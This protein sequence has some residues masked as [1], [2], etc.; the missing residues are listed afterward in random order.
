M[1]M[2]LLVWNGALVL[3]GILVIQSTHF[4]LQMRKWKLGGFKPHKLLL[5]ERTRAQVCCSLAQRLSCPGH[6]SSNILPCVPC[7]WNRGPEEGSCVN[8]KGLWMEE[9]ELEWPPPLFASQCFYFP[10]GGLGLR[11]SLLRRWVYRW[12]SMACEGWPQPWRWW[13]AG[14]TLSVEK[15]R[16]R[17][18]GPWVGLEFTLNMKLLEG[19]K[20][21]QV[22]LWC[23]FLNTH[24]QL[25][26]TGLWVLLLGLWLGMIMGGVLLCI[27]FTTLCYCW[28][29]FDYVLLL[30]CVYIKKLIKKQSSFLDLR[31]IN[32]VENM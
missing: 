32:S 6:L 7:R 26:K 21:G 27:L 23:P 22:M 16:L 8:C 11:G 18:G 15:W 25:L 17:K 24:Q 1:T 20:Q 5:A 14:L 29:Y 28:N 2:V 12:R 10:C 3:G 31:K 9:K 13:S 30:L 19:F 4:I